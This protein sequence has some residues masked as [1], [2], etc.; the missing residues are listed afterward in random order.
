MDVLAYRE[1]DKQTNKVKAY[2][3]E[4]LIREKKEDKTFIKF[5]QKLPIDMN[6]DE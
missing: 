3:V 4:E 2:I 5:E 6:D 1:F